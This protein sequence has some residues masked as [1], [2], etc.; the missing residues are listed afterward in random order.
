MKRIL[1]LFLPLLTLYV[2]LFTGCVKTSDDFLQSG[3][4]LG[5]KHKYQEALSNF[6]HAI[7]LDSNNA[8]A[9]LERALIACR[10]GYTVPTN[11]DLSKYIELT[12]PKLAIAF[13]GRALNKRMEQNFVGSVDDLNKAIVLDPGNIQSFVFKKEVLQ[14]VGDSLPLRQFLNGLDERTLDRI[15]NYVSPQ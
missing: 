8:R 5:N 15:N 4:L 11:N 2:F 6:N 12:S 9:Y 13:I 1:G 3:I 10:T 7:E 14:E